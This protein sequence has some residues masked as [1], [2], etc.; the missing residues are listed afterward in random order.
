MFFR[1]AP[2]SR[3]KEG[4]RMRKLNLL[5]SILVL[6]ALLLAACG[7]EG[8]ETAVPD[9]QPSPLTEEPTEEPMT[10]E[11]PLGTETVTPG[12]Q[13]ATPGIPVTGEE[14]PSRLSN[15]L[16]FD[17]W[18]QNGE[19]IG[20]VNDM[21]LDLDNTRVTYVIVG[22][23]G[24]LEIG[25][26]DVLVPWDL[27][28]VQTAGSG[29]PAGDQNAFILQVDQELFENA[30]DVDINDILPGRGEPAGDWDTDI[31]SYWETGALPATALPEAD[32]TATVSP[33]GTPVPEATGMPGVADL[34]GVVLASEVLG[35]TVTL[36]P[37]ESEGQGSAQG[38]EQATATPGTAKQVTATADPAIATATA[39]PDVVDF[40]GTIDDMIVDIDGGDILYVVVNA[41]FE[42]GDRWIPVPLRVFQ[43]DAANE[44]FVINADTAS[45]QDAPFFEDNAWPDTTMEGWDDEFEAFWQ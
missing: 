3:E 20:E 26:K 14:S 43:W 22:T 6:A 35:S 19:Q 1:E 24:F 7:A 13:T 4:M 34:Q 37:S 10:T 45:I 23:G 25:E 44:A 29:G 18:N 39:G 31:H 36:S 12:D 27:L 42:E 32:A 9:T 8:T 15:Q 5:L 28:E 17:V 30:P 41:A 16:N 2:H 21:I 38:Q 40:N 33:D 11:T